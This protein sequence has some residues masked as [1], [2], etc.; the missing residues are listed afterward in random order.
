MIKLG[1]HLI[2]ARVWRSIIEL[3]Q[4]AI[5]ITLPLLD[6]LTGLFGGRA[7]EGGAQTLSLRW[8]RL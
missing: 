8:C 5:M 6:V 7:D 1:P 4:V 2:Q 3:S